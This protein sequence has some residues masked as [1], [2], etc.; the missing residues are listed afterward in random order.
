MQLKHATRFLD[1]PDVITSS[2]GKTKIYQNYYMKKA[3]GS[4]H[5]RITERRSRNVLVMKWKQIS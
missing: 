1:S 2:D 5:V 3:D 4:Y